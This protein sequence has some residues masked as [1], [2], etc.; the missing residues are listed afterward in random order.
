MVDRYDRGLLSKGGFFVSVNDR[1]VRLPDGTTVPNGEDFRNKFHLHPLAQADLFVPCGGRPAAVNI[2]N[3][4][5]L[6]DERG[7]PKFRIIVEGAN[8]FI[9]EEARLRLEERGVIVIKDSSANK[10]GVTSSSLEVYASLA[11]TDAEYEEHMRVHEGRLSEFRKRY[12]EEILQTIQGNARAEF[13][14][15]WREHC[16]TGKPLT[17]LSNELS[18][19]INAIT[20]AVVA[21]DLTEDPQLMARVLKLYTPPSLLALV[22]LENIMS[23]VP[24]SYLKA[25]AATTMATRYIYS[26]GL[27]ANEVDFYTFVRGL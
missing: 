27:R 3:W 11:L 23:R 18:D 12:I 16:S 8:L 13:E 4:T 19:R 10:G 6:L 25:I 21:S 22:G 14:T 9:T 15:L 7:Q 24:A 17:L 20:D 1:E 2:T 26:R 5:R